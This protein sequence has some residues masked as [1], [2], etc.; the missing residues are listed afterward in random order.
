MCY[1]NKEA[2]GPE[3]KAGLILLMKPAE[4]IHDKRKCGSYSLSVSSSLNNPDKT[5]CMPFKKNNNN[6]VAILCRSVDATSKPTWPQSKSLKLTKMGI[7]Q[8]DHHRREI[9]NGYK[10]QTPH[11][12]HHKSC[13]YSCTTARAWKRNH[14][15]STAEI[16]L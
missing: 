2:F 14:P 16:L 13:C 8:L 12:L 6:A 1:A 9:C 7:L 11:R 5:K 3:S 15:K 10:K 4:R